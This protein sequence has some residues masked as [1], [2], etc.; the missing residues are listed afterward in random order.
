MVWGM[1]KDKDSKAILSLLPKSA[2]YYWC[3]PD[4]PRGKNQELLAEEAAKHALVGKTYPSVKKALETAV[5]EAA[6]NDLIFVGGSVFVV[7]EVI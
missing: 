7:A 5:K 6:F 3:C 4:V 2:T 1:V